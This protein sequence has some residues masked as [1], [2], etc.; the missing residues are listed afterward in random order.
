MKVSGTWK[1]TKEMVEDTR[2]GAMEASTKDTG[3][4]I[5]PTEEVD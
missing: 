4:M 3:K 1:P 2:F 5:K